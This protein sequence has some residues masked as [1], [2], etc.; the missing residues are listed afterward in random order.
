MAVRVIEAGVLT[1][2]GNGLGRY[3]E[4]PGRCLAGRVDLH[5]GGIQQTLGTIAQALSGSPMAELEP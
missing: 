5:D 2:I 1:V 4:A 3:I